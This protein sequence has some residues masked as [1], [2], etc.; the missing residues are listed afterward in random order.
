[1]KKQALLSLIL[2]VIVF[3]VAP[4]ERTYG[5][6][7]AGVVP[8]QYIVLLRSGVSPEAVATDHALA[9]AFTYRT[10]IR[11]FAGLI[12]EGRVRALQ[13]DP[14]VAAV[15]P[16]RLV[17]II[18]KPQGKP[19]GGGGNA[20]QVV[21]AGVQRIGA[22]TVA[23]NGSGIGVAIVDTGLDFNHADLQPLG[24]ASFSAVSAS[25]QDDHGHGTHVGGI[26]AARD[27]ASD[28]V[29]VADAAT[30]YAVKVLDRSGSGTDSQIIAGLDWIAQNASVVTPNIRAANMSLGR[31]GTIGDNPALRG[32]IQALY[33]M[34][35]TVVAAAGNDCGMEVSEMIPAGYPEVL[36][37]ASSTA[38]SGSNQCRFF[39]GF[40]ATDTAS[41]FTTDGKLQATNVGVTISAPGD[42]KENISKSCFINSVGILSTKLGGGTTRMSG[43]SMAAPHVA[44]VVAL[45]WQKTIELG[46]SPLTVEQ[47]RSKIR[48][49]ANGV[50]AAPLNSPAS[51]YS[52]DDEREGVVSAPGALGTVQ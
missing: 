12:P 14:R 46:F 25:A 48:G 43:T 28:V 42:E 40:I 20:G 51:C 31:S 41:Y 22:D 2:S 38:A 35:I 1:M 19:G 9:P 18:E 36:A 50:G 6:P 45:L 44:G 39:N 7:P 3:L 17:S 16:D 29:G 32:A 27:N 4:T 21:P 13:S 37:I 49:S 30:L 11:G 47:A 26:V 52:F 10:A 24:A 15:I 33:N 23:H 5:Q 34:D 8:G